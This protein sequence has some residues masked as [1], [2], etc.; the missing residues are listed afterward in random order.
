MQPLRLD[1]F[2]KVSG[3]AVIAAH[4]GVE[5][6]MKLST[7][8]TEI[9]PEKA[10]T[11]FQILP[12]L[13]RKRGFTF[14]DQKFAA[15]VALA[16][17]PAKKALVGHA[18]AGARGLGGR[19]QVTLRRGALIVPPVVAQVTGDWVRETR[20]RVEGD[21]RVDQVQ[22]QNDVYD[23]VEFTVDLELPNPGEV[24]LPSIAFPRR[25]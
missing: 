17:L 11:D 15:Q 4:K 1:G 2:K 5:V 19:M 9:A 24:V 8:G 23:A 18:R 16:A 12:P 7:E 20:S 25:R 14:K 10:A 22:F 3:E 6:K 21:R 13:E